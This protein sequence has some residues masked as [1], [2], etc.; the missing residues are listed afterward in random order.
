MVSQ[1]S[2][3]KS[4]DDLRR[5]LDRQV[6][7][8]RRSMAA[9]DEGAIEEAE[10]LA[11]SCYV[12][13]HDGGGSRSLLGQLGLKRALTL[14]NSELQLPDAP[15]GGELMRAPPLTVFQMG[16]SG[17]NVAPLCQVG[18]NLVDIPWFKFSKWWEQIIFTTSKGL[19]LKR[20]NLVFSMR[21]QDGG[22]HVDRQ[23]DNE[24]YHWLGADV[25]P[26]IRIGTE[27]VTG[28]H[29]ATMRQI[30][31]EVDQALISLEI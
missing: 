16:P 21:N 13:L 1:T 19:K 6:A 24:V 2:F 5:A 15:F 17:T 8:M 26:R 20:M 10:R 31:W 4:E 30:S 12:L 25:D 9:Y 11:Q 3:L 18:M 7:N 27:P 23:I 28:A 14:P 29:W 22:G